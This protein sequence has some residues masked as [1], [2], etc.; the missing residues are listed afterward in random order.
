MVRRSA[1]EKAGLFNESLSYAYDHDMWIK[2]KEFANF[3]YIEKELMAYRTH[4]GQ[5]SERRN[6][7]DEGFA[8]LKDAMARHPYGEKMRKERLAVLHYRLAQHCRSNKK[9]YN[10]LGHSFLAFLYDP[11]RAMRVFSSR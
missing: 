8:V 5:Q 7:W 1:L 11:I 10:Y 3:S 4:A 9:I 2:I 6:Q